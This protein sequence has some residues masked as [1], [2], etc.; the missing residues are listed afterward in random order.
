MRC[1]QS[2]APSDGVLQ[3]MQTRGC[4]GVTILTRAPVQQGVQGVRFLSFDAV[5]LLCF[6]RGEV[7]TRVVPIAS[8]Q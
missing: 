6:G 5:Q 4:T 3:K 8:V 2:W 1:E 7:P